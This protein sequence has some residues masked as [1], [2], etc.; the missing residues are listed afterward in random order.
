[1]LRSESLLGREMPRLKKQPPGVNTRHPAAQ[2]QTGNR[3]RPVDEPGLGDNVLVL[4]CG[5]PAKVD[6]AIAGRVQLVAKALLKL[7]LLGGR[8]L[9]PEEEVDDERVRTGRV[10]IDGVR[11]ALNV[12]R[13]VGERSLKRRRDTRKR[14]HLGNSLASD[15][16]SGTPTD[17]VAGGSII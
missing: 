2:L 14:S 15:P 7:S 3:D 4:V 11:H 16:A 17:R 5:S 13:E 10:H 1:M 9:S 6:S 12:G 8:N